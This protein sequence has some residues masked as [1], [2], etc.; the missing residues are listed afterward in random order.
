MQLSL[1]KN[2]TKIYS[3]SDGAALQYKNR[4]YI[5]NLCYHK[6]D[7]DMDAKLHFFAMPHGIGACDGIG[8]TTERLA[9]KMVPYDEQMTTL[10]N[11]T[12]GLLYRFLQSP[13]STALL[14]TTGKK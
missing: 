8:G 5:I 12:S 3:F 13:L 4:K 2:L 9:R 1:F 6:D 11:F 10:S 7:F 14:K